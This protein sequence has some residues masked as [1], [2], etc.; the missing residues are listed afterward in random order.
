[1]CT[2]ASV[3]RDLTFQFLS[4][5][6]SLSS[7][8]TRYFTQL[9]SNIASSKWLKKFGCYP[10]IF[11]GKYE[12]YEKNEC[13]NYFL[14]NFKKSNTKISDFLPHTGNANYH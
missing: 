10:Q 12:K 6:L 5:N 11:D 8:S 2:D 9:C 3:T 4:V 7:K 14:A 13:C 1:M